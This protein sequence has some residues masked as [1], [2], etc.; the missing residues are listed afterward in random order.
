MN[1]ETLK[2]F[3]DL[4][5]TGS[6]SKTAEINYVSQSAVSQQIKKLE[7]IYKSK[8]LSRVSNKIHP[9]VSGETL[10]RAA[11]K[12]LITYDEA[13]GSIR[14]S[15]IDKKAAKI[16]ISTIYSV[17]TYVLQSYIRKFMKV[18]PI[19]EVNIE[20]KRFSQVYKDIALG[21]A[22]FGMLSCH[23]PINNKNLS[24]S[25][26]CEE[27]MV[28][29]V[30]LGSQFAKMKTI[31]IHQM[32]GKDFIL[33]DKAFPS[34]KYI[35]SVFKKNKIKV[36]VKMEVDNI[37]TIKTYVKSGLGF[38][39]VPKSVIRKSEKGADIHILKFLGIKM[40]RTVSV[41]YNK[42]KKM[43]NAKKEFLEITKCRD[44]SATGS[45]LAQKFRKG[46]AELKS[47]RCEAE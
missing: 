45:H 18:S 8:L 39:I 6:F 17:G 21:R 19:T 3:K 47:A 35:D 9:T 27:E 36:N 44:D 20:Y 38:S 10:Y 2:V 1:I 25:Y 41:I 33:F 31:N 5:E 30:G 22:D 40:A 15:V 42:N 11:K 32:N 7:I 16:K 28:L 26:M 34:R 43:S 12:I 24:V 14:Q 37:E 29:I 13:I 4:V 23:A 46:A